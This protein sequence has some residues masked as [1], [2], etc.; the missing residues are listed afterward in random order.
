MIIDCISDTHGFFPDLEGGDLLIIAGDLTAK[1]TLNEYFEFHNWLNRQNYTRKIVIAGNH[2]NL[3]Q[4]G[5]PLEIGDGKII[6]AIPILCRDTIYLCDTAT[7]FHGLKI[8]GS[9]WTK[10]FPGMNPQCKAFTVDTE[11]E[12]MDKW[13]LI[14]SDVDI[15]IT[16]GPPQDILDKVKHFPFN[17]GSR[18]LRGCLEYCFRPKLWVWGHIHEAYGEYDFKGMTKCVNAS[19]VNERYEPVNKPI[20]IILRKTGKSLNASAPTILP[21]DLLCRTCYV[22]MIKNYDLM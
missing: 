13:E 20:R 9:P 21:L 19:H 16:H 15:L 17:V 2:D 5:L 10:S 12:L 11:D 14:P 6:G 4:K 8:F 3:C 18:T 1:D 22:K 7:E